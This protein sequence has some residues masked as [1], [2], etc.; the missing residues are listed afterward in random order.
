M[1]IFDIA[2]TDED[3]VTLIQILEEWEANGLA[4]TADS[5]KRRAIIL[6]TK[7][8]LQKQEAYVDRLFEAAIQPSTALQT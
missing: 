8:L 6:K 7:L 1:A 3:Y 5:R 4:E 2:F